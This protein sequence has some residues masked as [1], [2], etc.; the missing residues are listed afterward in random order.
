MPIPISLSTDYECSDTKLQQ[1]IMKYGSVMT[2]IHASDNGFK[3]YKSGVFDKCN[4]RVL[5]DL[6]VEVSFYHL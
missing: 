5:S 6:K 1:L 2:G 4:P 3:N